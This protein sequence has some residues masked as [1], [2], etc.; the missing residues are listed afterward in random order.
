M[1]D[2]EEASRLQAE[3]ILIPE[4]A[5]AE[6]IEEAETGDAVA[7]GSNRRYTDGADLLV[8]AKSRNLNTNVVKRKRPNKGT[9]KGH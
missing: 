8:E 9:T 1:V 6:A 5:V 4:V 2:N 7:T 3:G